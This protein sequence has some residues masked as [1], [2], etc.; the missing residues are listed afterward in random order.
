MQTGTKH[1]PLQ[2]G[3]IQGSAE[4]NGTAGGR[5]HGTVSLNKYAR[6]ILLGLQDIRRRL[7]AT[8][9]TQPQYSPLHTTREAEEEGDGA[10]VPRTT[11]HSSGKVPL[12]ANLLSFLKVFFLTKESPKSDLGHAKSIVLQ[13]SITMCSGRSKKTDSETRLRARYQ[14]RYWKERR[15]SQP[16]QADVGFVCANAEKE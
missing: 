15:M 6:R 16:A 7:D 13:V 9:P 2:G 14:L 12:F 3:T 1:R 11:S 10:V 8:L 5:M 4:N